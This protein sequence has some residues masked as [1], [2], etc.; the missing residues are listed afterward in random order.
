V[1][2]V[3][4]EPKTKSDQEKLGMAIQRLSDE[5]PTFTVKADEETGQTIIAGMGELHLEI[6]VDRMKREFRVEATVGKPQVAYRETLVARGEGEG[7]FVRQH[8]G[9]GQFAHVK[10]ALEPAALGAGTSF[11]TELPTGTIPK[12]YVAAVEA[13]VRDAL[14]RG[15]LAG[16][17][18]V[19]VKASLVDG[20]HHDVDSSELAFTVAASMA[21]R[22]ACESAGVSLLE[23]V[24]DLEVVTPDEFLGDVLGDLNS[25]RGRIGGMDSRPGLQVVNA[26]VPLAAMF[27]YATDLRSRTQGRATFSMQF[28]QYS[29]VPAQL[30]E[31]IVARVKGA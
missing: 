6:L 11:V 25:R 13:S 27:G 9:R 31:E 28:S 2:E 19:D 8:G 20:E 22:A 7:R 29:P 5:D 16:Y 15:F 4:I 14:S 12:D 17:P 10:L 30:S 24:M 1:I 21:V 26:Q 18:L 3:A 23:P